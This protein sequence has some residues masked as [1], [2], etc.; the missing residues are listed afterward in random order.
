LHAQATLRHGYK[1]LGFFLERGTGSHP[2]GDKCEDEKCH[3]PYEQNRQHIPAIPR[4]IGGRN[5]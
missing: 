5:I 3:G 4:R 1:P 2:D